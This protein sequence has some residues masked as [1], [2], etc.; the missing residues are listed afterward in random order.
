M[1]SNRPRHTTLSTAFLGLLVGLTLSSCNQAKESAN[2]LPTKSQEQSPS[3]EAPGND[4]NDGQTIKLSSQA[5]AIS[6]ISTST[7]KSLNHESEIKTTGEIK[8]DENRVFHINSIVSGRIIQDK[9]NLGDSIAKGQVLAL[10]QNL[11]V[12]KVYAEYIHNHH[13]NQLNLKQLTS[14]LDLATKNLKRLKDLQAEGIAPIKDV[15]IAQNL[16]DQLSIEIKGAEEHEEDL[17]VETQAMLK[18][19]GKTLKPGDD[20]SI[21][22]NSPLPSPRAGVIIKKNVTLGDVVN[23]TDP[24]Y[25]VADLSQVWLDITIY[26]KDLSLIKMGQEI[27]FQSDSIPNKSFHGTISYIQPIAG[28]TTRTFIAR[29]Q[30]LNHQQALKPGMFGT[31]LVMTREKKLLPYLQ[32]SSIQRHGNDIFVFL[33]EKPGLYH[34]TSIEL[35]TREGDGYLINNGVKPGEQV[36]VSGSLTLKA[37]YLRTLNKESN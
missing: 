28:D 13:L 1:P 26:D 20:H 17:K 19:Y 35:G 3:K 22:S 8:A 15:L 16:A 37:E 36:V 31:A 9:V 27:S 18:A 5:I 2:S 4:E 25:V 11:E 6:N 10:V 24:L 12:A 21:D 30:L 14:K 33:E 7:I 23:T 29:A 34:K 32:D